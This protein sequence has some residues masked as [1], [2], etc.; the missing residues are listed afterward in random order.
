MIQD[1]SL[2]ETFHW[3]WNTNGFTSDEHIIDSEYLLIFASLLCCSLLVQHYVGHVFKWQ[4]LPEAAATMMVGMVISLIIRFSGGYNN[5][6]SES[7][8]FDTT[9]LGFSPKIFFFGFLP[10][11]VFNR[12]VI[13]VFCTF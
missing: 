8:Y 5:N 7:T 1:R 12:F 13:P 4:Y 10:P 11:I 2:E 3:G 6:H 9:L